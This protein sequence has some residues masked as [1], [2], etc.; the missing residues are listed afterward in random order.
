MFTWEAKWTITGLW[1]QMGVK[2]SSVQM[3]FYF[4]CISKRP[5]ILMDMCRHYISGSVCMIF[6]H[7][8]WNLISAKMTNMKSIPALSFKRT[9]A[10]NATSNE[11]SLHLFIS[12][13][14]NYVHMKISCRFEISFRSKWP[15]WNPYRFEFHFASIH[16]NTSKELTEHRSE[17]FNRNEI[18]YRFEFI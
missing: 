14:V 16:V 17:I 2:T 11:S 3:K 12:F 7:L 4:D 6:Y 9:C 15:I 18:S 5:D 13:R 8:K 10:L 1:F